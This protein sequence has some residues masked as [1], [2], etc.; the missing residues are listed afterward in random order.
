M[1]SLGLC[2]ETLQKFN[3]V[4]RSWT[5][6]Q[7]ERTLAKIW[8]AT[9]WH[10]LQL[11]IYS[12][13]R[14][15]FHTWT[16]WFYFW[17]HYLYTSTTI[18]SVILIPLRSQNQRLWGSQESKLDYYLRYGW[19]HGDQPKNQR[20]DKWHSHFEQL[21]DDT[22][23]TT[24]VQYIAISVRQTLYL[25]INVRPRSCRYTSTILASTKLDPYAALNPAKLVLVAKVD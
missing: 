12:R 10:I 3:W 22:E 25:L 11:R 7:L 15:Q 17:T 9:T 21:I 16:L 2:L 18:V 24:S 13:K 8:R 5:P 6:G 19:H 20:T 4:L 1:K 14:N 23:F